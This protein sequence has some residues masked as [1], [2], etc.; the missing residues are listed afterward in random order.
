MKTPDTPKIDSFVPTKSDME[1]CPLCLNKFTL[2]EEPGKLGRVY[3]VC[4]RPKCMISIWLRDPMVG[5]WF[6]TESEPCPVC[7]EEKMRLFFRSDE[8]IKMLCPKCEC[9][10]ENV[11]PEKHAMIM[12]Y[13]ESKGKRI[14]PKKEK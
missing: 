3:L 10:V 8:Y 7:G 4:A 12:K 6:R 9:I 11:D 5:R 14:T 1:H 2:Y 13:E